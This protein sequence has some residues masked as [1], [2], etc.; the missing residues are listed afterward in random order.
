[1]YLRKKESLLFGLNRQLYTAF[2]QAD[3]LKVKGAVRNLHFSPNDVTKNA[4]NK[5]LQS[6]PNGDFNFSELKHLVD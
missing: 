2:L 4:I 5:K 6:H 1:M 3:R